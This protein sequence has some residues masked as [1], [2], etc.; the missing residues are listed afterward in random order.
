MWGVTRIVPGGRN[1][2]IPDPLGRNGST[3]DPPSMR[4][5]KGYLKG[6]WSKSLA[7]EPLPET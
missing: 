7:F 2:L 3:E 5:G 4:R 1:G 6:L